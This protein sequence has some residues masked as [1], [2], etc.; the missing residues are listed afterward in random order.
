MGSRESKVHPVKTMSAPVIYCT[1]CGMPTQW[2]K[3]EDGP[4]YPKARS[5]Y[6]GKCKE[7]REECKCDS[8][9]IDGPGERSCRVCGKKGRWSINCFCDDC[10]PMIR[11]QRPKC[12]GCK[13]PDDFCSCEPPTPPPSPDSPP[14]R[15]SCTAYQ[16][17]AL[18]AKCKHLKVNRETRNCEN[19]DAMYVE[20]PK[21]ECNICSAWNHT[22]SWLVCPTCK[23]PRTTADGKWN[24][25]KKCGFD[26]HSN[27]ETDEEDTYEDDALSM[28]EKK[29][30][31]ADRVKY[32]C[33][34]CE[35]DI[36]HT[37]E[38]TFDDDGDLLCHEC[39]CSSQKVPPDD[40]TL[41]NTFEYSR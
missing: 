6:C 20:V 35:R 22:P 16:Y 15:L 8:K 30:M 10:Y 9:E 1:K 41:L 31:E 34:R 13:R 23:L 21:C 12:N 36:G 18:C 14:L 28:I 38:V 17:Y 19:C 5:Y 11:S 40:D 29:R 4:A 3:C 33:K 32:K 26:T 39:A 27:S 7:S 37:R 2:C 25:C 24:A